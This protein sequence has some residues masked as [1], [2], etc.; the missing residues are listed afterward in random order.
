MTKPQIA[1]HNSY[2]DSTASLDDSHSSIAGRIGNGDISLLSLHSDERRTL[3]SISSLRKDREKIFSVSAAFFEMDCSIS[4][5]PCLSDHFV[6]NM[7]FTGSCHSCHAPFPE[8]DFT[9]TKPL[10]E[11]ALQTRQVQTAYCDRAG[12]TPCGPTAYIPNTSN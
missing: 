12:R 5:Y 10:L 6:S 4:K 11:A 2:R 1:C 9:L 8:T 3:N 7:R